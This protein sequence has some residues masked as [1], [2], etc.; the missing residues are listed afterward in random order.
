ME[1]FMGRDIKIWKDDGSFKLRICGIIQN[2][3]KYLVAASDEVRTFYSFPGGHVT[4][5]ENTDDAVAREV[6][7]ETGFETSIKKLLAIEQLFFKRE[8][9]MPFHEICYYYL[10][11]PK[12]KI[13]AKDFSV[14]EDDHGKLCHHNFCWKTLQELAEL[15]VRPKNILNIIGNGKERQHLIRYEN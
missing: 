14:D 2:G 9:G 5:G 8:D 4:L 13:E 12:Q 6:K 10:V 11:E 3:D 15:D 7:E 1:E